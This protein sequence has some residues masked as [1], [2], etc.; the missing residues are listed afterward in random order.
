M[1]KKNL[2]ACK[3]CL[4]ENRDSKETRKIK[5]CQC[6]FCKD[7]LEAYL[8][9]EIM[10]KKYQISCPDIKCPKYIYL[11]PHLFISMEEIEE[12]TNKELLEKHKNFRLDTEIFL[13]P[14]RAWCPKPGC[15]TICQLGPDFENLKTTVWTFYHCPN[16]SEEFCAHCSRGWHQGNFKV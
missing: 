13:D 1:A 2:K 11:V 5:S 6:V 7:C 3:I 4:V 12:I 9:I 16:C 10:A 14:Q 15:N 8:E